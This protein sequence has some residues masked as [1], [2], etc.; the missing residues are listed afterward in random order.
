L[1]GDG[2]EFPLLEIRQLEF[3]LPQARA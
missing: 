1:L 2:E 3:N